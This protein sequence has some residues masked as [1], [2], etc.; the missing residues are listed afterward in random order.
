MRK[1]THSKRYDISSGRAIYVDYTNGSDTGNGSASTPLK[2]ITAVNALK[3]RLRDMVMFKR[4]EVWGGVTLNVSKSGVSGKPIIFDAY[5]SGSN[6]IIKA[7]NIG[8]AYQSNAIKIDGVHD[9]SIR[10]IYSQYAATNQEVIRIVDSN[11][12]EIDSCTVEGDNSTRQDGLN[13]FSTLAKTKSY[14]IR[15][16]KVTAF[17]NKCTTWGGNGIGSGS[18]YF[19]AASEVTIEDCVA[20]SNGTS[21]SGDHGIYLSKTVNSIIARTTTYNNTASGVKLNTC[22]NCKV[23]GNYGYNNKYGIYL[24]CEYETNSSGNKVFN[25][26]EYN[27]QDGIYI[28]WV[29]PAKVINNEFYHNTMVMNGRNDGNPGGFVVNPSLLDWGNGGANIVKNN[30]MYSDYL[31]NAYGVPVYVGDNLAFT[32]NVWDNN[33]VYYSSKTDKVARTTTNLTFAAYQAL[34]ADPHGISA[35]PVFVNQISNWHLQTT[36]PCKAAGATGLDVLTDY[37]GVVRGAAVDIGAY[38]YV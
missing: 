19:P 17:N 13:I 34:G 4:N 9:I 31:V 8:G 16:S 3:L 27:N 33:L 20:Y 36:S 28:T 21:T 15:I 37:D 35:N 32:N 2:T 29:A 23:F 11:N 24:S 25:N 26:L 30:I 10:N 38:E 18:D 14:R 6:P 1:T 12:I 7:G 22:Q 5:D